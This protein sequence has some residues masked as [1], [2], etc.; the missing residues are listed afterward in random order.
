MFDAR[1]H[2]R[3]LQRNWRM[4]TVVTLGL[5]IAL[6]W[7]LSDQAG[8]WEEGALPLFILGLA[9]LFLSVWRFRHYK[10]ALIE[11]EGLGDAPEAEAAW[12]R[13]HR[14]QLLG[15]MNAKLPAWVGMLHFVCVAEVVPLI[16][17]VL[18]SMG[19]MLLYRPPSAW[20][21]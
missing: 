15:L 7:F 18:A 8:A 1:P 13:L 20:V 12:A 17:L 19:V 5:P 16:L 6:V 14:Q 21:Q 10:A 2:W 3:A 9:T 11:A 4:Q